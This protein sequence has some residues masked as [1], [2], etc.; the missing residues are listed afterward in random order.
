MIESIDEFK[1]TSGV[2]DKKVLYQY[3]L[4]D[5]EV[6][7]KQLFKLNV[8]LSREV[9]KLYQSNIFYNKIWS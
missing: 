8:R 5:T 9:R 2:T 4:N 7:A 6:H 1:V 3:Y